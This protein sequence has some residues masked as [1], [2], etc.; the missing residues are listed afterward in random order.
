MS[1]DHNQTEIVENDFRLLEIEIDTL[2]KIK[3]TEQINDNTGEVAITASLDP[4]LLKSRIK[5][6]KIILSPEGAVVYPQ[7]LYLVSK[8]RGEGKI[9]DTTTIAKALL[10]F[11]RFLYSTHH[12]QLNEDGNEIPAE[13]LTYKSLSRY[14]EEGAPWRFA[15]FLIENCR[16]RQSDGDEA[17]SL[18]TART[19]MGAV[20]GFYKWMQK[21]GYLK[22]DDDHIVTHFSKGISLHCEYDQHDMLAH[23]KSNARREYE[24]SNIMK[25]FPRS[26]STPA[27]KKLK[28]MLP[29]HLSLFNEY[30][31][32]LPKPFSLMFRLAVKTGTRIEE[33]THFPA[34]NIGEID[35]SELDV[36]PIRLTETKGNKPRTIEIPL[37][38]YEELEQY[39]YN[40]QRALNKLKRE[41]LT[42]P[43]IVN[44][45]FISNKGKPY[46][47]NTLEK[48][49]YKLREMIQEVDPAWYYRVHDCRSTFATQ[50]L[51]TE[52][53]L[54]EVS[55]E[56]LIDELSEL[57]GHA[58]TKTTEKYIKFMNSYKSQ[59]NVAKYKNNKL[60]GGW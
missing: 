34:H 37:Y 6:T 44:Y 24:I 46:S 22:N 39:K 20:I 38:L 43:E 5:K 50:W 19:Y 48:H 16:H 45:L 12:T 47:E 56:F 23:T 30:I 4:S 31:D 25:M 58:S 2:A 11:T 13:N 35:V 14:E 29:E 42:E 26:E 53:K 57:M 9:Q 40:N 7:S 36:V 55:Y 28:P 18:T 54:R 52:S 32:R 41:Q 60:N 17:L 33:L 27:H 8:L 15:E 1:I 21:Y 59:I 10:M 3:L 49:F 51:L